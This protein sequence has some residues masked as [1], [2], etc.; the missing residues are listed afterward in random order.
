SRTS[1]DRCWTH[2]Q[3]GGLYGGRARVAAGGRVRRQEPFGDA[4]GVVVHRDRGEHRL[5]LGAVDTRSDGAVG[6]HV[7][8][9][10]AASA[11]RR[12]RQRRQRARD[13]GRR[14]DEMK[15]LLAMTA[16]AVVAVTLTAGVAGAQTT[17]RLDQLKQRGDT[18]IQRRLDTLHADSTLVAG[19]T[20]LAD[21]DRTQLTA[22]IT[23][24][25]DGLRALK[26]KVDGETQL[27]PLVDDLR[28]VVDDYRVYVLVEP[29]VHLTVAADRGLAI[30]GFFDD[31][32]PKL[33]HA[34]DTAKANGK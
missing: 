24:D 9:L 5:V 25:S 13:P 12:G 20:H 29:Q 34:I 21:G 17:P 2:D 16:G 14:P 8:R 1:G 32:A 30:V 23:H 6:S 22:I 15:R 33:Q 18:E 27:A 3:T 10:A 7:D 26:T 11:R 28:S 19:A 4:G 31:I